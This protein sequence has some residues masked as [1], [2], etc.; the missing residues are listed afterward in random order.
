MHIRQFRSRLLGY[1]GLVD[2][3]H[4]PRVAQLAHVWTT[5]TFFMGLTTAPISINCW[6]ILS[7][8]RPGPIRI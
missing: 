4:H 5:N 1:P 2:S 6:S 8:R 3:A 7:F